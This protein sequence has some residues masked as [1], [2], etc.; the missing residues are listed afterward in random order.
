MEIKKN[1][2]IIIASICLAV[3]LGFCVYNAAQFFILPNEG[4]ASLTLEKVKDD[5]DVSLKLESYDELTKTLNRKGFE[6]FLD[7]F[8]EAN[9]KKSEERHVALYLINF[10]SATKGLKAINDEYGHLVGDGLPAAFADRLKEVFDDERFVFARRS[11]SAFIVFDTEFHG[12]DDAAACVKK[13]K[14]VWHD[15]PYKVNDDIAI[16]GLALHAFCLPFE[17]TDEARSADELVSYAYDAAN[18]MKDL[19]PFAFAFDGDE[20]PILGD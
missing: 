14:E 9:K 5:L 3:S 2:K 8:L 18:N 13:L 20:A 10:S 4:E 17:A 7:N 11:G 19:A 16:E 1:S 15:A 12:K 6:D